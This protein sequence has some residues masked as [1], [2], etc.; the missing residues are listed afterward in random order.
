MFFVLL[1]LSIKAQTYIPLPENNT[2]WQIHMNNVDSGT[3]TGSSCFYCT[4]TAGDILLNGIKYTKLIRYFNHISTTAS[5]LGAIRNDTN[6]HTV[7]YVPV[8]SASK[9]LLYD[10]RLTSRDSLKFYNGKKYPITKVS[11]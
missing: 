3:N 6:E 1:S 4:H 7:Y 8:N 11:T 9:L 10:F 5:Y 2:E